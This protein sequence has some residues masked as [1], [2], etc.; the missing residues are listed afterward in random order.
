[1]ACTLNEQCLSLACGRANS[2]ITGKD[3][4]FTCCGSGYEMIDGRMYCKDMANGTVCR[5]NWQC[6]SK[7]CVGSGT[8]G[9]HNGK[10]IDQFTTGM[11]CTL[12][13]QCLSLACGRANSTITGKDGPFTCCGSGYEMI[14]GRMYCK[15]MA[16]GTVCRQNWQ[17]KSKHCVGSGTLGTHNGKCADQLTTGMACKHNGDCLSQSCYPATVGGPDVCCGQGSELV[18]FTSYCK[19]QDNTGQW[20]KNDGMCKEG[21]FC[22]NEVCNLKLNQGETC[23]GLSDAVASV[24]CVSK[25]CARP[26]ANSKAA[27]CCSP[28][29]KTYVASQAANYCRGQ[30]QNAACYT[31]AMCNPGTPCSGSAL[32]VQQGICG[33]QLTTGMSCK[34]N[35]ECLSLTCGRASSAIGVDGPFECCGQGYGLIDG[36]YYCNDMPNGTVCK[37]DSQ[38]KSKHC[39]DGKCASQLTTGMACKHNPDC[40]SLS[41]NS[42][43]ADGSNVCCG[44]GSEL[45]GLKSYCKGQTPDGQS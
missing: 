3:G 35:T 30:P 11:A 38:C 32:G 42:A 41:C 24:A 28:L 43:T 13:E 14:D 27:V 45:V 33:H 10:C 39:I 8:L 25:A 7:H 2:T 31:T 18:G 17:C 12:N 9:S 20:C 1:M 34:H 26:N 4:P 37:Q 21:S 23:D 29:R 15:D 6:K 22:R 44:Q 19:K 36:R 16:N 5:Q 40:L